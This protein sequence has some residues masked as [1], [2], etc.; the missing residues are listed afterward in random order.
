VGLSTGCVTSFPV[1]EYNLARAALEA[2]KEAEA[3]RLSAALFHKANEAY[4][5][6]V[7]CYQA[8][9]YD[10]ARQNFEESRRF[11]E[12]AENVARIARFQ[13]GETVP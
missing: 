8:R 10:C 6:A 9:K 1:D 7:D 11:S 5:T 2:A 3:Q 4:R 13:S 12:E